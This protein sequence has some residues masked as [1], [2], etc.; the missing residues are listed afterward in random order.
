MYGWEIG[1]YKKPSMATHGWASCS[2]RARPAPR[3][4][5]HSLS[6]D[7]PRRR[8]RPKHAR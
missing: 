1:P 8:V 6:V 4:I 5:D 2:N 7:S 3:K